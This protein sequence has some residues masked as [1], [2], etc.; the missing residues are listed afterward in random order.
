MKQKVSEIT[1]RYQATGKGYGFLIPE[2]GGEDF[3][4]PPRTEGGAWN[5]DIVRAR[6]DGPALAEGRRTASVTGIVERS[7]KTV[8]GILYRHGREVWLAPDSDR[9]PSAIRVVG[10]RAGARGGDRAA[11]TVTSFGGRG[12]RPM[13]VLSEVFGRSDSLDAISSAILFNYGIN[14]L[15]P[16]EVLREAEHAPQTVPPEALAGRPDLRKKTIITIDGASAKDLDD[17]VSL[18]RDRDGRMVLGVHIADVSHYVPM[19]GAL[20]REAW[21]RGT[22]VYYADKVVPMLPTALSNGICSLNPDVDRLTLSCFMTL[23]EAGNVVE[24]TISKSVIRSRR[25]MTY[26]NCNILL[27]GKDPALEETYSDILP[28][29]RDMAKLA[30]AL[31]KRRMLRGALDLETREVY[32]RCDESGAPVGVGKREQGVSESLIEEFMLL[33]NETVAEHLCT[34]H[35]PAVYR[36]HEKPSED[37]AETLRAMLAPMGYDLPDTDSFSLQKVLRRAEGRPESTLVH[38]LVLRS[39]MKAR[40]DGEN[41]GHFGLAAKFYCHFTSPIR[42]YPDLMVHRAL[43]AM[44]DHSPGKKLAAAVPQAAVQSSLR[45]LAAMNAEREIEKC[46]LAAYMRQHLGETFSGLVSGVA[47]FG[48]FVT[49]EDGVEGLVPLEA[50]PED[51]YQFDEHKL[52]LT[53]QRAKNQFSFGMPL[54]VTCVSADPA[55]GQVD[56]RL[57]NSGAGE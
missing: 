22:S 27:S 17:A 47:R 3:F 37:K 19:G 56:F 54:D 12:A 9:L 11:L 51:E 7:N 6:P 42:R 32:I 41:L 49:T 50:L 18:E 38:M 53:G 20:D 34:L 52:A 5:G 44:L 13:G 1:G 21:D 23:D 26:E 15:F 45:E 28:M 25:R 35:I 48:L 30:S 57:A 40:Y 33:A 24:H 14:P 43:T 46:Y 10:R 16:P 39:L 8:T 55:A 36:V 29:L 4:L 2:N 31:R